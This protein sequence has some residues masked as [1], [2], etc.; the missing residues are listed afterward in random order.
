MANSIA[1]APRC[2]WTPW[3]RLWEEASQDGIIRKQK[4]GATH[5]EPNISPVA[6]IQPHPFLPP[7]AAQLIPSVD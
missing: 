6:Y 2:G 5:Q 3:R 1:L 7:A 4:E